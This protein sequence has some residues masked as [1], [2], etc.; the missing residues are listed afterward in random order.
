MSRLG[1]VRVLVVDDDKNRADIVRRRLCEDFEIVNAS[2]GASA[3]H[4]LETEDFDLL[5]S[6]QARSTQETMIGDCPAMLLL[7]VER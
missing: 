7:R 4:L 5:I 6:E 3:R 2:P 1:K